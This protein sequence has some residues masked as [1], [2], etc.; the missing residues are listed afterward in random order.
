MLCQNETGV[1]PG[2]EIFFNSTD[3]KTERLFYCVGCCGHYYCGDGYRVN[4]SYMQRLLLMLIEKGSIRLAYRGK[5]YTARANDIVLLDGTY[6]QYYDAGEYVEFYWIHLSGENSSE[7][8]EY[9]MNAQGGIVYSTANRQKAAR[10]LRRVV[11]QFAT[12]Q[13]V[14]AAEQSRLLYSILCRLAPEPQPEEASSRQPVREAVRYIN[15]NLGGDLSLKRIAAEVHVSTPHLVRLF[16]VEMQYSPHE[17]IIQLRMNRAKY[18]LSTTTLPVKA[19]A[20]EVGYGS[21]SSFSAA[22]TERFGIS[23][24]RFRE[25][26]QG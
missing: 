1:L 8:C 17:Y 2:S 24:G 14:S 5:S 16:K 20:A 10:L 12:G 25:F 4:R 15:K 3:I 6:P 23:P 11:T 21:E 9:L 19:I 7:L 18:L 26:P 22:F 13:T